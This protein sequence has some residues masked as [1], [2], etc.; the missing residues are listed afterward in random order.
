MTDYG[1]L[2]TTRFCGDWLLETCLRIEDIENVSII[3]FLTKKTEKKDGDTKEID[4]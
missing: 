1:V 4:R 3:G 2:Q